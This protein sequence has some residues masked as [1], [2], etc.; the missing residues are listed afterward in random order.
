MSCLRSACDALA[1]GVAEQRIEPGLFLLL[2]G[3]A[4]RFVVDGTS[5]A[6]APSLV[7]TISLVEVSRGLDL[8]QPVAHGMAVILGGAQFG[9]Q[10]PLHQGLGLG[11]RE[12]R[13]GGRRVLAAGWP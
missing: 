4:Q 6:T 5:R 11:R 9:G 2:V 10:R 3:R 12:S 8:A 7:S 13:R 1:A